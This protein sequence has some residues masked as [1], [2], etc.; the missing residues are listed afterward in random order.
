M[1]RYRIEC[2]ICLYVPTL[3]VAKWSGVT[4]HVLCVY[5]CL[6]KVKKLDKQLKS[7][8]EMMQNEE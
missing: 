4:T 1:W 6:Q 5:M 3:V 7:S 2:V 8:E